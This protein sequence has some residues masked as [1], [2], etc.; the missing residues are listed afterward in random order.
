MLVAR[1]PDLAAV[2]GVQFRVVPD[3]LVRRRLPAPLGRTRPLIR[4]AASVAASVIMSEAL[5]QRLAERPRGSR[6]AIAGIIVGPTRAVSSPECREFIT[7]SSFPVQRFRPCS[8]D[9]RSFRNPAAVVASSGRLVGLVRTC[10]SAVCTPSGGGS[11]DAWCDRF[12][13]A[14]VRDGSSGGWV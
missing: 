5:R 3:Q 14:V 9:L 6:S 13:M 11:W 2:G 1:E 10:E 4:H 12:V 7:R 8:P